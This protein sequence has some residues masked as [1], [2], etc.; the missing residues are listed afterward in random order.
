MRVCNKCREPIDNE[1]KYKVEV[2]CFN[3]VGQYIPSKSY[4][5]ELCSTCYEKIFEKN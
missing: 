3:N 4:N 1:T 2:E 5:L